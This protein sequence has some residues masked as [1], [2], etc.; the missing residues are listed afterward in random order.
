MIT[1]GDGA[2]GDNHSASVAFP[3]EYH[4]TDTEGNVGV[5]GVLNRSCWCFLGMCVRVVTVSWV[6][7]RLRVCACFGIPGPS[8]CGAEAWTKLKPSLGT[9]WSS[10]CHGGGFPVMAFGVIGVMMCAVAFLGE[11]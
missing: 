1:A 11:G 2:S 10:D 4:G 7:P 9:A 8:L 6:Q 5:A 3:R